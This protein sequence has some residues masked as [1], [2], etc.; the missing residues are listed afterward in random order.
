M[1]SLHSEDHPLLDAL[2]RRLEPILDEA[3]EEDAIFCLELLNLLVVVV[4]VQEVQPVAGRLVLEEL[5][6]VFWV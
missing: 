2:P 4:I 5:F 6:A 1:G 3:I